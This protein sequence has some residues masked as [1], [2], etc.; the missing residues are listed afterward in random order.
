MYIRS[1]LT[2]LTALAEPSRLRI[3]ELLRAGPRPVNAIGERLGL[4]QPQ[5]SKHLK[6]LR[7]AG[8]VRARPRAQQRVYELRAE[9]FR[10]L[11]AWLAPY[12]RFWNDRL[13]ALECRLDATSGTKLES[14]SRARN[15]R[16]R[17]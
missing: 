13:D 4:E 7:E 9:P 1:V 6:V 14:A 10:E 3:V 11:D 12:R 16:R 8:L 17:T 15:P 2:T 5:V